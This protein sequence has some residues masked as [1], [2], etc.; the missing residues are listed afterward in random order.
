MNAVCPIP[1][2]TI[3][4]FGR[5]ALSLGFLWTPCSLRLTA[6]RRF[7][8]E[9]TL[10]NNTKADSAPSGLER[11][12]IDQRKPQYYLV[13]GDTI[14]VGAMIVNAFSFVLALYSVL[15]SLALTSLADA[16]VYTIL[17]IPYW[18]PYRCVYV[19]QL[20]QRQRQRQHGGG[21]G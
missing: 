8:S 16:Q 2:V 12:S 18:R 17:N 20:L 3:P 7:N 13:P 4:K 9:P 1:H 15:L 19:Q 14:M 10:R 11:S 5:E 6:K 21:G